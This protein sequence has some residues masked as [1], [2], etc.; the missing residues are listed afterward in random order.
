MI[1][2]FL[3]QRL[4]DSST[5]RLVMITGARQTGKT[6]LAQATYSNLR[7]LSLDEIETR[8]SL[9]EVPTRAWVSSV[10]PAILDEAQKEPALFEKLKFA[11]DQG[12]LDFSVILGSSQI[13]MLKNVRETL[14]GR[15]FIYELW[16]LM[17]RELTAT[18]DALTPPLLD[19]LISETGKADDL[20]ANEPALLFGEEAHQQKSRLEHGLKWGM[21]P[22][23][24]ELSDPERTDW[25]RSYT[26]TY[27]ER[28]LADLT[29]LDDLAPF[30]RFLRLAALRSGQILSYADLARDAGISPGTARNYLHYLTLSYQVILLQPYFS[31][32]NKS[33][34]KAPKLYWIDPGL[35]RYQTGFWGEEVSGPLFES[36]VVSECYK[37]I[38]TMRPETELWY[39][40]THGGLEV[41]MLMSTPSGVWGLEV[42][43][44]RHV[45]SGQAASLR[46]LA[47]QIDANW[48]GGIVVYQGNTIEKLDD[49]LWAIPA[50]RLLG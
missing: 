40:R 29:R 47:A 50:S 44:N 49:N 46:R 15:V 18:G 34:V 31:N 10:G 42:K 41:D 30:R 13:L 27:L 36:F 4:P 2:R 35:W 11:F 5:R 8:T 28:D 26:N 3:S 12:G 14:T 43:T 37:W 21:M 38:K 24:P 16:P 19:R 32:L 1:P 7:Y 25:L 39:Y 20:L 9:R 48:R 23:L 33:L 45:N 6:T 22:E 17:L